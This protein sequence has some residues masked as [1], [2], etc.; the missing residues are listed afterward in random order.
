MFWIRGVAS[1]DDSPEVIVD[2]EPG[3]EAAEVPARE[4]SRLTAAFSIRE[5]ALALPVV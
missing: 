4:A 3:D 1:H 5:H 2:F